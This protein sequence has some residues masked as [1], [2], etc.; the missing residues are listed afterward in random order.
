MVVDIAQDC[1]ATPDYPVGHLLFLQRVH[2]VDAM[3]RSFLQVRVQ[4]VRA[5]SSRVA[6]LRRY[7]SYLAEALW[8]KR[9]GVVFRQ[10]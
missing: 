2:E 5:G 3:L 6:T 8:R 7:V 4:N 1:V 9:N 10:K